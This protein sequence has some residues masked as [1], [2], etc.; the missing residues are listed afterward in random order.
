MVFNQ[1]STMR[2]NPETVSLFLFLASYLREP[3]ESGILLS[4]GVSTKSGKWK[5]NLHV[6]WGW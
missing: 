3:R 5:K 4:L 6:V 1:K 2:N